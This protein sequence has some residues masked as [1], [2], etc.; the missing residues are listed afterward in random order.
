MGDFGDGVAG[1]AVS[2]IHGVP[3]LPTH[4]GFRFAACPL[5]GA[6]N[7]YSREFEIVQSCVFKP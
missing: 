4:N 2:E 7:R 5:S 1:L 6:V 3:V